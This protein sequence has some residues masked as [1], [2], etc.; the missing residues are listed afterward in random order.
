VGKEGKRIREY[1]KLP[2][3]PEQSSVQSDGKPTPPT[4]VATMAAEIMTL[5]KIPPTTTLPKIPPVTTIT[6]AE[7]T[8]LKSESDS[9]ATPRPKR[10]R[11]EPKR[12]QDATEG[13][14]W[15]HRSKRPTSEPPSHEPNNHNNHSTSNGDSRKR[16]PNDEVRVRAARQPSM[17]H[18]LDMATLKNS[19]LGATEE[20]LIEVPTPTLE[21]YVNKRIEAKQLVATAPT[22]VFD[23]NE[24]KQMYGFK[25]PDAPPENTCAGCLGRRDVELEDNPIV[26]CDGEGCGREYHL[27]CCNPSLSDEKE[28]E[29]WLCQDC[30]PNG[31]STAFL[32][33]Y[34]EESDLRKAE[35]LVQSTASDP[36]AAF[37]DHLLRQDTKRENKRLDRFPVS[38]LE[39]GALTDATAKSG[40]VSRTRRNQEQTQPLTPSF[41]V[42]KPIRIFS[43]VGSQYHTGRIV[44]WRMMVKTHAPSS[45]NDYEFLIRFPAGVEGRKTAYRHWIVL[46]EHGTCVGTTLV[47]ANMPSGEWQPS[48]LW[49]RTARELIPI[50]HQLIESEGQIQYRPA[51]GAL[52]VDETPMKSKNKV[53][54]LVRPFGHVNVFHTLNAKDKM[55]DLFH[56]TALKGFLKDGKS[57]L[58]FEMA[59]M[60]HDE[61][62][63]VRK[64]RELK[65]DDP[66]GY[67]A[68][69]SLDSYSLPLLQPSSYGQISL[70]SHAA[71][72]PT[73]RRGLDRSKL[74]DQLKRRGIEVT[75]D[76]GAAMACKLVA[77]H[78]R[79]LWEKPSTDD[80][81][82][83]DNALKGNSNGK[84]QT[85]D[86]A[87]KKGKVEASQEYS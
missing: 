79:M 59:K 78:P 36:H 1:R 60:E 34:L 22:T 45:I 44:D 25:V 29:R 85:T 10:K 53:L 58:Q 12:I 28:Q 47:W 40:T 70:E 57:I 56:E 2:A 74:F 46:E 33:R 4:S 49:L 20:H 83:N 14:Q 11:V 75:K 62:M 32:M 73:V 80:N 13:P 37:I 31:G 35:F 9:S 82:A 7:P 65:L 63:K 50:Q 67:Y 66:M 86:N 24:E 16:P 38:Q 21:E 27:N 87:P 64:W 84:V 54:A 3:S 51:H 81:V 19:S 42:G 71:L 17:K 69:S 52:D 68:L 72:C 41:F 8:P 30:C 61:Q 48:I 6:T 18:G 77:F 43:L 23:T 76:L 55:M 5:P 26:L 15:L 39:R